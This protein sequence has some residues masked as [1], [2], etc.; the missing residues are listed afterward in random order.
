MS[1]RSSYHYGVS[2]P[3]AL[4]QHFLVGFVSGATVSAVKNTARDLTQNEKIKDGIKTAV[5]SGIAAS[6]I[7]R[8]NR[9][10][11]H[12]HILDAMLSLSIGGAMVYAIEKINETQK[13]HTKEVTQ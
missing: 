8:A 2:E 9:Q 1:Q 13:Q 10:M 4:M 12:G 3:H 5:Q 11:T 6:S 7:S